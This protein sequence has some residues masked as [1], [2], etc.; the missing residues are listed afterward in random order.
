V[1]QPKPDA[2]SGAEKLALG[3]QIRGRDDADSHTPSITMF[4]GDKKEYS[5]KSESNAVGRKD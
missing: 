4:D 1:P 3:M 2:E 5:H